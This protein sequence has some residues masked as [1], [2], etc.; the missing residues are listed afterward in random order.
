METKMLDSIVVIPEK[1][2]K[3]EFKKS[4]V[5]LL[6][7]EIPNYDLKNYFD[8]IYYNKSSNGVFRYYVSNSKKNGSFASFSE[9]NTSLSLTPHWIFSNESSQRI[10]VSCVGA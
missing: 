9:T 10:P 6:S 4:F 7:S 1:T 2:T 5:F 8:T 3:S